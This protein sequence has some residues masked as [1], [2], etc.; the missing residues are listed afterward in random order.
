MSLQLAKWGRV[1]FASLWVRNYR[2]YFIGQTISQSGTF[3]QQVAQAWLVLKLTNSGTALGLIAALQNLPILLFAPLGGTLADRFSKRKLLIF[4][5]TGFGLLALI[6]GALVITNLVQLW[7][8][9]ALALCFG[10][11][12]CIDN[13]TRQSFVVEMVGAPQLRNA[14]SLNSTMMNLSRIVGPAIAGVLITLV[15]M[16]PCFIIN[17][18]SYAAVIIMLLAMR[19]SELYAASAVRRGAGQ[20]VEGFRY[21]FSTPILRNMLVIMAIIGTLT[22]E[23]Q[24]SLPLLAEFTFHGD[25]SSYAAL[26][27]ALGIGAV[28][29]GIVTASRK[30]T[31][32]NTL[33]VA[34]FMFG[35]AALL[36]AFMPTLSLAVV[37][38]VLLGFCSIYFSSTGNTTLQLSS[39]PQMRGRIMALWSMAML[40]STT[41]GGPVIGFIGQQFG[42][43]WG[44]ATGGIA[45]LAAATFGFLAMQRAGRVKPEYSH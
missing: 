6:L 13:P 40:G 39:D 21:A 34:A 27:S 41:I 3:M 43:R 7:H 12:N 30:M 36:A 14:V 32:F 45:A 10:L 8:V 44:L 1:T 16:A 20:I 28:I 24:V 2:L 42:P 4:T 19:G 5:Q 31:S 29:G 9:A 25:A 22:Y 18:L 35:G 23:F 38:V 17:G 33:V 26:T 11:I 37:G 15:G